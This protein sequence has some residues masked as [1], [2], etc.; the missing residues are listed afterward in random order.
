MSGRW[1][2]KEKTKGNEIIVTVDYIQDGSKIESGKNKESCTESEFEDRNQE[3]GG[4]DT[5][6]R[7]ILEPGKEM[8]K[9]K[10]IKDKIKTI[11]PTTKKIKEKKARENMKIS[12]N[13]IEITLETNVTRNVGSVVKENTNNNESMVINDNIEV[14]TDDDTNRRIIYY[15]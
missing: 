13:I 3:E 9:M 8:G 11:F 15:R 7:K 1:I 4:G 10:I 2:K 6:K 5:R 14:V 12:D